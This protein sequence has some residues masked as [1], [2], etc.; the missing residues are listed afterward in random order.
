MD[1]EAMN[2]EVMDRGTVVDREAKDQETS[3]REMMG[4]EMKDWEM[5]DR[6]MKDRETVD[7]EMRA[8]RQW[9]RS[10]AGGELWTLQAVPGTTLGPFP[11]IPL[12]QGVWHNQHIGGKVPFFYRLL[13]F[14]LETWGFKSL[15]N[16][17]RSSFPETGADRGASSVGADGVI[18]P[19]TPTLAV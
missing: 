15:Q 11:N 16:L 2:K 9:T 19:S 6:E 12:K 14:H 4:R 8:G 18:S 3:D 7:G 10:Q 13:S 5:M 1:S 17:R